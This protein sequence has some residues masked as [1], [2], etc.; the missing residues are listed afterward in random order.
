M[1]VNLEEYR[2]FYTDILSYLPPNESKKDSPNPSKVQHAQSKQ[3]SQQKQQ[4]SQQQKAQQPQ[5]KHQPPVKKATTRP[6]FEGTKVVRR[7]PN[8]K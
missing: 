3:Q 2:N 6:G 4:K 1:A 5:N 7:K 8:A